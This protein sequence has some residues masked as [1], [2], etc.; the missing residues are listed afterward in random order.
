[1]LTGFT[2]VALLVN[3]ER[4]ATK[5]MGEVTV[6]LNGENGTIQYSL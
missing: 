3:Q 2:I 1:V 4:D 5:M 6:Q